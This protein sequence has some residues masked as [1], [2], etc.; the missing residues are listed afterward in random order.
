MKAI[1]IMVSDPWEFGTEHGVGPLRCE[2]LSLEGEL[3]PAY[4]K[5]ADPLTIQNVSCRYVEI[6][7][8]LVNDLVKDIFEGRLVGANFVFGKDEDAVRSPWS[9]AK[10]PFGAVGSVR[11]LPRVR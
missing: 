6:S 8:R 11:L 9:S 1:E 2:L 3:G 4:A 7:T 10:V 5:L